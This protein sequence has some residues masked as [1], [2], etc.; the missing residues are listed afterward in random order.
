MYP[1]HY[2]DMHNYITSLI[3]LKILCVVLLT[4]S[5]IKIFRHKTEVLITLLSWVTT[6]NRN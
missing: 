5:Q 3:I 4:I 2:I 1:S 6:I